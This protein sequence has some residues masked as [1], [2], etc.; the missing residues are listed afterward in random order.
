MSLIIEDEENLLYKK[1]FD[2]IKKLL[3]QTNFHFS[4]HSILTF[5]LINKYGIYFDYQ[6]LNTNRKFL[7][8]IENIQ[9]FCYEILSKEFHKDLTIILSSL[10]LISKFDKKPLFYL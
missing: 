5:N 8:N 7:S 4:I 10:E 3:L 6:W 2:K 9:S 1:R